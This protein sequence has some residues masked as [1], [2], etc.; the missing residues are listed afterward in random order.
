MS[1]AISGNRTTQN[2]GANQR[3]QNLDI[4]DFLQ[5]MLLLNPSNIFSVLKTDTVN[6]EEW[7]HLGC[8][9]V[10]LL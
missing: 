9:A 4:R 8:Y 3:I 6:V 2:D 10:W 7:C 5:M 1:A